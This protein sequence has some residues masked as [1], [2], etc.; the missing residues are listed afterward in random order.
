MLADD[1]ATIQPTETILQI[2]QLLQQA[3]YTELTQ[4]QI[5]Y[6]LEQFDCAI[7]FDIEDGLK[8]LDDF[9]LLQQNA[10]PLSCQVAETLCDLLDRQW[11]DY[12]DRL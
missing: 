8:K 7:D 2:K 1:T 3:N 10:R 5:E 4:Q 12:I 11:Q 9:N 6:A